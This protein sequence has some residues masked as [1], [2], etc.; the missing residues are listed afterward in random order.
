M[1][2]QNEEVHNGDTRIC[3]IQDANKVNEWKKSI[4]KTRKKHAD[5]VGSIRP[6]DRPV[7]Y[8]GKDARQVLSKEQT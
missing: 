6:M 4:N 2:D 5:Q 3:A 8:I 1:E 7:M